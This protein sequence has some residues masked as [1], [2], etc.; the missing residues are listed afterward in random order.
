[1]KDEYS[2]LN[3]FPAGHVMAKLRDR[4][5]DGFCTSRDIDG[6]SSDSEILTAGLVIRRQRPHGKVVF[7]T[8]ED[9]F[10]LI[11]L[12][13]FPRVYEQREYEFKSP[14]LVVEG[15]LSKRDGTH[16]VV[17]TRVKPFSVFDKVPQSKN[18][19]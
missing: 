17:V 9:E 5:N 13:I 19:R 1:M 8:L 4:F 6:L 3:L 7:M 16:N 15:K 18:W 2:V 11:P 14:F 10:G 12:M